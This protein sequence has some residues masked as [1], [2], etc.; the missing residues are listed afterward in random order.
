MTHGSVL[1]Y[2]ITDP[3]ALT[4]A[5]VLFHLFIMPHCSVVLYTIKETDGIPRGAEYCQLIT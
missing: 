4:C 5:A 3:V 1:L 2:T